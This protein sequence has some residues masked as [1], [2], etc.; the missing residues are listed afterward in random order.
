MCMLF[1]KNSNG[2]PF[3]HMS[4]V[5]T[6]NSLKEMSPAGIVNRLIKMVKKE[7]I[8]Y[9]IMLWWI[10]VEKWLRKIN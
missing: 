9:V 10:L 6:C 5:L 4:L 8:F 7:P 3:A 1:F 2:I